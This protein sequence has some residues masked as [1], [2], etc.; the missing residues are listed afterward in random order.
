MVV[1]NPPYVP[2]GDR[3]A[4]PPEV[5]AYE[6]LEALFA[7]DDGLD[8]IRGL[9][10]AAA[11]ALAPGGWLVFE[12]GFGQESAVRALLAAGRFWQ[13]MATIADLQG[14]PRVARSRRK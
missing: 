4:L 12:F 14:I 5:R 13:D 7:G 11:G 1:S 2:W 8:V 10:D 3:I 9:I 6:P